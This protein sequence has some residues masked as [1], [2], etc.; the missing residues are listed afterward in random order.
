MDSKIVGT[1]VLAL[2]LGTGQAISIGR[3]GELEFP[4]G[5]YLYAGSA[6]GPGGLQARLARH[7]RCLGNDKRVH[8]HLD[9][10][11]Q[12]STWGG[13]WSHSSPKRLECS[14]ATELRALPRAHMV[15]PGFGASDCRCSA[16]LVHVPVLPGDDWFADT[17]GAKRT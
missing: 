6:L 15:A 2:W 13:A 4:A 8:W 12:H 9:Y 1:Y 10:L 11:R 14:W 16:H 5:W 3:L 7:R 17:L